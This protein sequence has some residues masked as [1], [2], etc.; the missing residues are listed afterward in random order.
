MT[1]LR[2]ETVADEIIAADVAA[3]ATTA[4]ASKTGRP[5]LG[6]AEDEGGRG[7]PW[8]WFAGGIASGLIVVIA[9]FVT[10]VLGGPGP[11]AT[12]GPAPT[13]G[14][15]AATRTPVRATATP[16]A[17][18]ADSP[19]ATP[20]A[21]PAVPETA[22]SLED[23]MLIIG[24]GPDEV[25]QALETV[26][27]D[28]SDD[29][30]EGGTGE[31]AA[32]QP[33]VIDLRRSVIF[34]ALVAPPF[35]ER[36]P[37]PGE[38]S[39]VVWGGPGGPE[40]DEHYVY[41]AEVADGIAGLDDTFIELGIAYLDRTPLDGLAPAPYEGGT[42][43]FLTGSNTFY[44]FRVAADSPSALIRLVHSE[45]EAFLT[46]EPTDAFAW[47]S[48]NV[49]GVFIPAREWEGA[50]GWRTF[51]FVQVLGPEP[52]QVQAANDASPD[53]GLPLQAFF[54]DQVPR[55]VLD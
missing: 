19:T 21:T 37:E 38:E 13:P 33:G 28:G 39:G 12:A 11:A 2:V 16:T 42:F 34:E 14:G 20:S 6:I 45:G 10:G 31:P 5:A 8:I 15:V 51:G 7:F 24:L 41:A 1:E 44:A 46:D 18:P 9:L 30:F 52:G 23:Y 53:V 29:W 27:T 17:S 50:D 36:M 55:F 4:R 35:I 26:V 22:T 48:E 3:A 47:R 32:I 49:L 40:P 25:E 54:P 43:N